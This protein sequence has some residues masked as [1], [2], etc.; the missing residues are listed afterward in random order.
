MEAPKYGT[1]IAIFPTMEGR[2]VRNMAIKR[3]RTFR[4]A[5][6]QSPI[7]SISCLSRLSLQL[8]CWHASE[9]LCSWSAVCA[10]MRVNTTEL[11]IQA[12]HRS[13][14]SNASV[15]S[16]RV[17]LWVLL[18]LKILDGYFD[19][20]LSI[21]TLRSKCTTYTICLYS[22]RGSLVLSCYHLQVGP[23]RCGV[24]A[25]YYTISWVFCFSFKKKKDREL[26]SFLTSGWGFYS[27]LI[28]RGGNKEST[29]NP[30]Q[31]FPKNKGHLLRNN[32]QELVVMPCFAS[33]WACPQKQM[34]LTFL[35]IKG[36]AIHY[37]CC[38][39]CKEFSHL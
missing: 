36:M 4:G 8:E 14:P 23:Y 28:P 11:L 7:Y 39:I 5:P 17:F 9:F 38:Y 37:F 30:D 35:P 18:S 29:K 1:R 19:H 24:T 6:N 33:N 27:L 26:L 16:I 2:H 12:M 3:K 25:W 22:A 34:K 20:H 32:S 15:W 10:L 21:C 31:Q 13:G